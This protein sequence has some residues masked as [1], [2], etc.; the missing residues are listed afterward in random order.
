MVGYDKFVSLPKVIKA[1][2][3]ATE[4]RPELFIATNMD[5][6]FLATQPRLVVPGAGPF[7][8]FIATAVGRPPVVMGKPSQLFW[9]TIKE[10]FIDIDANHTLMVGDQLDTDITFGNKNDFRATL[11]VGTGLNYTYVDSTRIK[12]GLE[13][14]THF[15]ESLGSLEKYFAPINATNGEL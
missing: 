4:V 8:E 13:R 11:L 9:E 2:S 5:Q 14:P 3:Y 6:K 10:L 1:T 15:A 12:S 7:V